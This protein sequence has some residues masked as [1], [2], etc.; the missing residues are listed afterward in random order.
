MREFTLDFTENLGYDQIS[1]A[2]E[3]ITVPEHFPENDNQ[4][5]ENQNFT[6]Y[7][8]VPS[9][10]GDTKPDKKFGSAILLFHGLNERSWDKYRPWANYLSDKTGKPVIL[11]PI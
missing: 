11:F 9:N 8:V 2:R 3:S 7:V 4:I 1:G 6:Y 5:K 10:E